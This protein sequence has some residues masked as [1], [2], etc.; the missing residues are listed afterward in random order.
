MS[1]QVNPAVPR[2]VALPAVG[3]PLSYYVAGPPVL[4]LRRTLL[5]DH[6][7]SGLP[8]TADWVPF[9]AV[10]RTRSTVGHHPIMSILRQRL[11]SGT[12]IDCRCPILELSSD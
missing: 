6:P 9:V 2:T 4:T 7:R 12:D 1:F 10:A 11:K 8:P 3:V 5:A